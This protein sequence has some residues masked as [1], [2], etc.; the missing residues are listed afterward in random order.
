MSVVTSVLAFFLN[1]VF[2][3]RIAPMKSQDFAAAS[4]R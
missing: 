1:A 4:R 3:S 2:G